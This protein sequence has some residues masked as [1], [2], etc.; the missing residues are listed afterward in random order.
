MD[1]TTYTKIKKQQRKTILISRWILITFTIIFVTIIFYFILKEKNSTTSSTKCYFKQ[2]HSTL[3]FAQIL[4]RHGERTPLDISGYPNDPYKNYTYEPYGPSALTHIGKRTLFEVG[5]YI[6]A[7]YCHLLQNYHRDIVY[8]LSSPFMRSRVSLLI[9]LAA[10]FRPEEQLFPTDDLN[11]QPIAYDYY[12]FNKDTIFLY[13]LFCKRFSQLYRRETEKSIANNEMKGFKKLLEKLELLT[14]AKYS[15]YR[16]LFTLY[17]HLKLQ[18]DFGLKLPDWTEEYMPQLEEYEAIS[19]VLSSRTEEL[20]L[21]SGGFILT[22]IVKS[23]QSKIND[24]KLIHRKINLYS[25][26]DF[27]IANLMG[28]LGIQ[29]KKSIPYGS[30]ISIELH[31]INNTY[32]IKVL[33]HERSKEHPNPEVLILDGCHEFCPLNTFLKLYGQYMATPDMCDVMDGLNIANA[34]ETFFVFDGN[35]PFPG[36]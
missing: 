22:E 16:D 21:L 35:R 32:N 5:K 27:T 17:L 25:G 6:K 3:I 23:I 1:T 10:M 13:F 36:V 24:P 4:F 30:Y 26:H 15:S 7:H 31:K 33:Y 14:G 28:T 11:W 12:T 8:P 19:Y 20:K 18:K 2:N 9:V 34:T 29:L